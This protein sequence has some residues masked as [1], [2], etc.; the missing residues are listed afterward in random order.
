MA[1]Y[2]LVA[3]VSVS[4]GAFVKDDG[5][6]FLPEDSPN[7]SWLTNAS[8]ELKIGGKILNIL[9]TPTTIIPDFHTPCLFEGKVQEEPLSE[10]TVSGFFQQQ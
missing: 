6:G 1:F 7:L 2:L 5:K 8:L 10:V 4:A 3:F 9:L